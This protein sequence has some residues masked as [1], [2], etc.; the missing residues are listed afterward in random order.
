MQSVYFELNW[1]F[2]LT[3]NNFARA[4]RYFIHFFAIVAPLRHE[5]SLYH[6]L[7]LCSRRTQHKN[8]RF[9]YLNLDN[10]RYD[11][12]ENFAKICQMKWNWIRSVKFEIVRIDY[13]KF[14]YHGNVTWGLLLSI[15]P[16]E[17]D[18]V[19]LRDC[20]KRQKTML[21]WP[22]IPIKIFSTYPPALSS[23]WKLSR[24]PFSSEMKF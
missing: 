19:K 22:K 23:I 6:A 2:I 7:P 5:I 17:H 14:C 3:S 1:M 21:R 13:Q 4:S 24:E 18:S 10:N 16:N 20:R 9:L 11:P 8:C 12:K 15:L